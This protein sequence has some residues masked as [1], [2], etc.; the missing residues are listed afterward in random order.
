MFPMLGKLLVMYVDDGITR[1]LL[2]H[3]VKPTEA[4]LASVSDE[5]VVHESKLVEPIQLEIAGSLEHRVQPTE[6]SSGTVADGGVVHEPVLVE[7]IQFETAGW[8]IPLL[9]GQYCIP[10]L[11]ISNTF[12]W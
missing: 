8:Q 3:Q 5:A 11:L 12:C 4:P 1:W 2:E 6:A 10:F 9:S 7:Q